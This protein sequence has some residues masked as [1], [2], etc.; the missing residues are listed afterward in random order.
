ME[1]AAEGVA[2]TIGAA[3]KRAAATSDRSCSAPTRRAAGAAPVTGQSASRKKVRRQHG[4]N[5]V[6]HGGLFPFMDPCEQNI[7][8]VSGSGLN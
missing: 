3:F 1:A 5:I 6:D 2:G 4:M 8:S 7:N